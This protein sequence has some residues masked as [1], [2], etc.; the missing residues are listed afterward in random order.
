MLGCGMM[1]RSAACARREEQ[2]DPGEAT[3]QP[4][5]YRHA[6]CDAE[7]VNPETGA[8]MSAL[9]S[10]AIVAAALIVGACGNKDRSTADSAGGAMSTNQPD[11]SHLLSVTPA[12][13]GA[14]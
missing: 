1:D 13:G 12:A 7:L 2:A 6:A 11:S 4:L 3:G 14:A 10:F 5:D 8:R 9:R